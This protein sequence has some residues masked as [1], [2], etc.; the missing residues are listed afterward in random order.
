MFL[1]SP[2][3]ILLIRTEFGSVVSEK[4]QQS[5]QGMLNSAH[6]LTNSQDHSTLGEQLC[7]DSITFLSRGR[8]CFLSGNG[9]GSSSALIDGCLIP[10]D[11]ELGH[12]S[13][14]H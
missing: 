1:R 11:L 14:G 7:V 13:Q 3:Q 5:V 10:R 4:T 8:L 2:P 12:G 6:R 9:H